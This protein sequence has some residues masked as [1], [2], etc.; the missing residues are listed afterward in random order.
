MHYFCSIFVQSKNTYSAINIDNYPLDSNNI[1]NNNNIKYHNFNNLQISRISGNNHH[2][3]SLI[4]ISSNNFLN[5]DSTDG[6]MQI[7]GSTSINP[8][9]TAIH[10]IVDNSCNL[11]NC[12]P[13]RSE[14]RELFIAGFMNFNALDDIN[15]LCLSILR[16]IIPSIA[17][18]EISSTRLVR[19][20]DT[21]NKCD[22]FPSIIVQ[23][24]SITR[25]KQILI[26][27]KD[28]NYYSTRDIDRQ[29]LNEEF[30]SRLPITKLIINDVLSSSEYKKYKSLKV[31]AK[32][33]GFQH[34]W[35]SGGKFLVRWN[36]NERVYFFSTVTDLNTIHDLYKTTRSPIDTQIYSNIIDRTDNNDIDSNTNQ[37]K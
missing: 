4:G 11:N 13:A 8:S 35:H 17:A 37:H 9:P 10:P 6:N 27:K 2:N 33:L 22:S 25:T 29:L 14:D 28:L 16:G 21:A 26:S 32:N 34:V 30:L 31:I 24:T 20:R 12:I 19:K 23:L 18:N 15:L 5:H 1:L 3:N 7:I 36:N